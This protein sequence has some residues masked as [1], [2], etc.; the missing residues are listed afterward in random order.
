[1]E[2]AEIIHEMAV[3]ARVAAAELRKLTTEE[4]NAM[5]LKIA[6]A[7]EAAKPR[8]L[9]WRRRTDFPRRWWTV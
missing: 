1:M 3:K 4:K 7:L 6:D 5:L 8:T 2:I 9:R